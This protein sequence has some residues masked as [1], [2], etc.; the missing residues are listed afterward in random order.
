LFNLEDNEKD[1]SKYYCFKDSQY[2]IMRTENKKSVKLI[3]ID[4]FKEKKTYN[5]SHNRNIS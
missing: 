1:P 3:S 4:D 5:I 2:L